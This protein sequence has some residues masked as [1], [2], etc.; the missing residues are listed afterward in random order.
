MLP[1]PFCSTLLSL[2]LGKN[3]TKIFTMR[4]KKNE[5]V[6]KQLFSV[7]FFF[8]FVCLHF[9]FMF[10][11]FLS[12]VFFFLFFFDLY[13]RELSPMMSNKQTNKKIQSYQLALH[14]LREVLGMEWRVIVQTVGWTQ[15][16]GRRRRK[17]VNKVH[18][19]VK[20]QKVQED[21]GWL[22]SWRCVNTPHTTAWGRCVCRRAWFGC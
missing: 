21:R 9:F 10:F 1:A 11:F 14:S 4:E 15:K 7:F 20:V 19:G 13:L 6:E 3:L 2:Q 5:I 12:Y 17:K 22:R 18:E 16:G 8:F